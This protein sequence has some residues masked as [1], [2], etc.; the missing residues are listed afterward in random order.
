MVTDHLFDPAGNGEWGPSAIL[1]R[2]W[3]VPDATK[4]QT[5][6]SYL[7]TLAAAEYSN[8]NNST[9][10]P[11]AKGACSGLFSKVDRMGL[12]ARDNAILKWALVRSHPN[13]GV[14]PEMDDLSCMSNVWS[15]LPA[16][17][18]DGTTTVPREFKKRAKVEYRAANYAEQS[19]LIESGDALALFFKQG[20]WSDRAVFADRLFARPMAYK[21]TGGIGLLRVA[22]RNME[23]PSDWLAHQWDP[24]RAL[25]RNIGCYAYRTAGS[26]DV[27][28]GQM[29]ALA[30]FLTG[31]DGAEKEALLRISF[32]RID[33]AAT[34]PTTRVR[35]VEISG[36]PSAA[37]LSA[38]RARH[39]SGCGGTW[40]PAHLR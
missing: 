25:A 20:P 22:S 3:Y 18:T 35:E 37:E 12:T 1:Q 34:D 2:A 15:S 14:D 16:T 6:E 23:A 30:N 17:A 31:A 38:I 10:V 32:E 39:P 7:L 36:A 21:D 19:S 13:L 9:T 40:Q 11:V 5:V 29:Y 26:T 28:E 4:P 27:P 8:F 33:K 24:S